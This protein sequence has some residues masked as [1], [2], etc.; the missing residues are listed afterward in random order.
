MAFAAG[1][2][3]K[4]YYMDEEDTTLGITNA[5]DDNNRQQQ[6]PAET[7]HVFQALEDGT[8]ITCVWPEALADHFE[9]L[10]EA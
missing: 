7:E 9:T 5:D 1:T 4:G 8:L 6:L 2:I 3:V 10:I